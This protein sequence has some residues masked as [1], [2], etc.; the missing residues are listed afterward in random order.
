VVISKSK[1]AALA[2]ETVDPKEV[3]G[4]VSDGL[5]IA[6]SAA[7]IGVANRIIIRALR[8]Q[9]SFD[10]DDTAEAVGDE[11][12]RLAA[13]QRDL[14]TRMVDARTKALKSKGR[15]RHQFDYRA[16]DNSALAARETIYTTIAARLEER[17]HDDALIAEIVMSARDR[18]WNDVG[19]AIMSH[20]N[21]VVVP[22]TAYGA[23]REAR[24][25]ELL[26]VDLA[27]LASSRRSRPARKNSSETPG[28]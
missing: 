28:E 2:A 21:A 17:S 11:L 9:K 13:E 25:K 12:R 19:G 3:E 10:R 20:V 24:L 14:A 4:A 16:D 18:A 8:E 5:L 7:T 26:D 23:Q 1:R 6:K 22:D 27:E 15:S